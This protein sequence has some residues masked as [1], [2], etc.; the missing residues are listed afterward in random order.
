[1]STLIPPR[2]KPERTAFFLDFDGT[3]VP[4][5][6]PNVNLPIVDD[7]LRFLLEDL[8]DNAG[9]A[10]AL[11][12][13]RTVDAI[14]ELF[15][16]LRLASSGEHGAEWRIDPGADIQTLTIPPGL[17][18]AQQYCEAFVLAH[19]TT[20]FERKHLSM[21]IHCHEDLPLLEAAATAA[22]SACVAGSGIRVLRARGMVEIKPED[23]SKGSAVARFMTSPPYAERQP[24]FIGDDVTDEDGFMAVNALGGISI[25]VGIGSSHARYRL[26][27]NDAVRE[28]IESLV[29]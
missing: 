1:M 23:A 16:P 29:G 20:R 7:G 15:N 14:D 8:R 27:D 24:V 4:F 3:L 6:K 17:D 9:G 2:L 25:K 18:L 13:G 12:S 10:L 11:I 28:W 26:A 22:Q 19:P 21:V 5:D